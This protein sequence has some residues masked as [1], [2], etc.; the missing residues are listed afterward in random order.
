MGK[1]HI[2]ELKQVI[3][4]LEASAATKK[5]KMKTKK[6]Q[7]VK[8]AHNWLDRAEHGKRAVVDKKKRKEDRERAIQQNVLY[9][10][11]EDNESTISGLRPH[12][13]AQP[14]GVSLAQVDAPVLPELRGEQVEKFMVNH[15]HTNK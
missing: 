3:T 13:P 8:I 7:E 9:V 2:E 12:A 11:P 6:E 15:P 4:R 1:L 14:D 5:G 10:R